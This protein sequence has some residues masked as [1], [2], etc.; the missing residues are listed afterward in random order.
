ME[1]GF[2]FQM[3]YTSFKLNVPQIITLHIMEQLHHVLVHLH[4]ML[5]PLLLISSGNSAPETVITP[6]EEEEDR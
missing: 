2:A 6:E 4:S 3:Q 5:P 1:F